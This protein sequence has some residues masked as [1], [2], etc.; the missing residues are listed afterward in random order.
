MSIQQK[1]RTNRKCWIWGILDRLVGGGL[2]Q[3]PT[4]SHLRDPTLAPVSLP[5]SSFQGFIGSWPVPV[6]DLDTEQRTNFFPTSFIGSYICSPASRSSCLTMEDRADPAALQPERPPTQSRSSAPRVRLSCESCRQRKVRCD[7]L[8]PCT[9]CVRLGFVCVPVERARLP[10][11]R[12]R[13]PPDRG[14]HTDKELADRVAKLEQLLRRVAERDARPAKVEEA[15]PSAVPSTSAGSEHTEQS[16]ESK[17]ADIESWR[18]Q[19]AQASTTMSLPHRPRPTTTYL[20]SSFW[21]DLMQ[22][23]S[24]S[25]LHDWVI[26]PVVRLR[27][28]IYRQATE[29]RTVLDDRLENEQGVKHSSGIGGTSFLGSE[30]SESPKSPQSYRGINITPQTR[31]SLCEIYLRNV[32]PVF[33]ILHRPSIRAFL[34]DDEPYLDYEPDHQV[35]V[36]LAYA[37]YYAAVCTI[38]DSHCQ[39][40]F[41]MD[42]KTVS[43]DLQRETEAALVKADFVTTNDITVLQAYVL[44]LVR[45]I[46][47]MTVELRPH[48]S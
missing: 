22:Q 30:S 1:Q 10:R 39:L 42:K 12:T 16:F 38:D 7:K 36:T 48:R 33:K 3:A 34:C 32:D 26:F 45:S 23:V 35:P 40:L 47:R 41:G 21:E 28:I 4:S 11:G 29:L 15:P 27:L 8:S 2:R 9:S 14:G 37:I 24:I 44:S 18:D 13:K 43:S 46:S 5:G 19:Q 17:M 31:R 20:A 25:L 6:N